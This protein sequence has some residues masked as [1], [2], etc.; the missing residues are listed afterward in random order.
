M[1]DSDTLDSYKMEKFTLDLQPRELV[2]RKVK[3]LRNKALVPGVV[4]GNNFGPVH[5]QADAKTFE[6][7]YSK[8]GETSLVDINIAGE[9]MPVLIHDVAIDPVSDAI[10]H[11]DFYKVNLKEKIT[12]A[13][14]LNFIGESMAVKNYGAVLMK[15]MNEIEVEGLPQDFPHAID[16]DLSAL[17]TRDSLILAKDINLP[18]GLTLKTDG[19]IVVAGTQVQ[20]EEII[21]TTATPS[22]EDVE[23]IKKEKKEEESVEE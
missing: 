4:Y 11:V 5:V 23:V 18:K 9:S 15:S 3:R 20:Q 2:G 21:D 13:I 1:T 12:T 19:D 6:K 22:I 10:I 14:P 17:S 8:A 16:V 7:V